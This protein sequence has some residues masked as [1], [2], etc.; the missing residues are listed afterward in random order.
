MELTVKAS[1]RQSTDPEL[2]ADEG[3]APATSAQAPSAGQK[4]FSTVEL[5]KS[6]ASWAA[7]KKKIHSDI[8]KLGAA[9]RAEIPDEA[10]LGV[11]L[12]TYVDDM[13]SSLDKDFESAL[14][15]VARAGTDPDRQAARTSALGVLDRYQKTVAINPGVKQVEK[16]PFLPLSILTPL[17]ATLDVIKRYLKG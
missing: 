4:E 11:E 16:N 2:L 3:D 7:A 17:N 15:A 8:E 10:D 9:I 6:R 12:V 1:F 13:L 14:D 5:A